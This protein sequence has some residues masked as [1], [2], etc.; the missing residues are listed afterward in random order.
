MSICHI[1]FSNRLRRSPFFER[2]DAQGAQSYTVYNHMLLAGHFRSL[3]EDCEHLKSAV[4]LWDVGAERQV[5]IKGPDAARLVQMT[6]PRDLSFMKEDQCYYIPMVDRSG[7]MLNDPV[8]VKVEEDRYWVSL[9]DSDMLYYFMGLA[10]GYNL[11][12]DVFE[13]DVSPLAIQGPMADELVRRVFG[14]DIVDTTFFRHKRIEVN[15]KSQVI[16]RSGWSLQGG[17]EIYLDGGEDGA[18][19]WDMLWEAGQDLD[20][21]AGCP[22]LIERIEGGLLSYGNDM[23]RANTPFEAG[24]GKFCHVDRE[25]E[26]LGMDAL[27]AKR[28][29]ERQLRA[30]S[31]SGDAVPSV[32][33]Y[34]PIFAPDGTF[35]GKVTSAVYSPYKETNVAIAMIERDYWDAGRELVVSTPDESRNLTVHESFWR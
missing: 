22:N 5:E 17:F 3:E 9:A 35:A 28:E 30:A 6:T 8:L 31:I 27:R 7:Y 29:P 26:C 13:P 10:T 34:W 1:A 25:V 12:V 16:A 19:L 24:L 14:Q 18:A 11:D 32:G 33:T 23:S 20:V 15:G 21:R 2:S 4:Q